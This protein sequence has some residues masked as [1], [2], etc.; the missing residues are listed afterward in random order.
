[1]TR[2]HV[3]PVLPE[4][5]SSFLP[6]ARDFE[7]RHVEPG[8]GVTIVSGPL[9]GAKG[10]LTSVEQSGQVVIRLEG[11]GDGVSLRLGAALI[12]AIAP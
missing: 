9:R 4:G 6:Y 8:Q 2:T 7:P 12:V 5:A 11:L 3:L 1:M 10:T